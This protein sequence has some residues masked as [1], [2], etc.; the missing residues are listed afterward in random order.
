MEAREITKI[1]RFFNQVGPPG[2][3]EI[4]F[5]GKDIRFLRLTNMLPTPLALDIYLE[6]RDSTTKYHISLGILIL[7]GSSLSFTE[8]DIFLAPG[9][10]LMVRTPA[11][12]SFSAIYRLK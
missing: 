11:A 12:N 10:K 1:N 6:H 8:E 7:N 4:D 9:Y 3:Y 5:E 2:A